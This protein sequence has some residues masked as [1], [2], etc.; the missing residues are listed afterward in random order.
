MRFY[1]RKYIRNVF[2]IS[3]FSLFLLISIVY[4]Q[5]SEMSQ[6]EI[7]YYIGIGIQPILVPEQEGTLRQGNYLIPHDIVIQKG[8]TLTIEAGTNI[9]LSANAMVVVNGTLNCMGTE[10]SPVAFRK[11]D[12][13]KYF[14]VPEPTAENRWDGIYLSD[15]AKLWMTNTIV[16]ESKYG[17]VVSGKDVIMAFDS[18]VFIDNKFQNVKI[19]NRILKV[20]ENSPLVFHYPEQ[21]G[22]FIESAVVKYATESIQEQRKKI[23]KTAYP[24]IRITMGS[25]AIG[26]AVIGG[27]GYYVYDKY[28][29]Q[30]KA[31]KDKKYI[32]YSDIGTASAVIG[33]ALFGAGLIGFSWTFFF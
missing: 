14:R 10:H 31:T 27:G 4:G 24:R 28:Y 22:E 30:Y 7:D 5:S 18:T 29:K 15:S 19:G 1:E 11:L 20:T 32:T 13:Q 23:F 6:E 3:F 8:K 21:E 26:G 17:I 33:A 9:F 16:S 25:I 2:K 12:N